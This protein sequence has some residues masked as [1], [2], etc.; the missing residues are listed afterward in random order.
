ME[1]IET[2]NKRL[3]DKYGRYLDYQ[4]MFRL[5]YSETILE[6]QP[7]DFIEIKK[8]IWLNNKYIL[9][10]LKEVPEFQQGEFVNKLSYEP[11]WV[12]EDRKGT[13]V[14][15]VWL[16]IETILES[17]RCAMEGNNGAKYEDPIIAE[18]DPKI[19]KEVKEKRMQELQ[20]ALFPNE[21]EVGDALAYREAI[22]VPRN[23]TKEN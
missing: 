15:P 16:A 12:F 18:N 17:M 5:V 3:I 6:K 11:I 10:G 7:P 20:E 22:V 2:L 9:E 23:Y 19:G 1:S 8:Y 13:P 4:A 21:S 14:P